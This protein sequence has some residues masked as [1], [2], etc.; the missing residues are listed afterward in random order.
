LK[1]ETMTTNK[2]MSVTRNASNPITRYEEHEDQY[3]LPLA[4]IYETPE[5]YVVTMDMPGADK[6]KMRVR[7]EQGSLMITAPALG[8]IQENATVLHEEARIPGYA[9]AFSLG[10]GIDLKNVDAHF[11]DG[12]LTIKL[13]KNEEMKPREIA[14]R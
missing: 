7:L 6:E 5:A 8:H 13:L 14:I 1:E 2:D 3:V 11:Q 9:R 4:D 10:E 12:V